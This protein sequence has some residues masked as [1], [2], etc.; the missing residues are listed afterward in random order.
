[1]E[2]K[3]FYIILGVA[4]LGLLISYTVANNQLLSP[5]SS[6]HSMKLASNLEQLIQVYNTGGNVLDE[7]E[8]NGIPYKDGMVRVIIQL[9]DE[10]TSIPSGYNIKVEYRSGSFVQAWV[11]LANLNEMSQASGVKYIKVPMEPLI[12]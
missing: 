12:D 6:E 11:P 3:H 2:R 4:F 7:A 10:K 8:K 9:E 1:M 5:K